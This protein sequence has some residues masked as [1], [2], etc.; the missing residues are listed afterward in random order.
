MPGGWER[1]WPPGV[2]ISKAVRSHCHVPAPP[3]AVQG[4]GRR[5]PS[6]RKCRLSLRQ[7]TQLSRSGCEKIGRRPFQATAVNILPARNRP[8]YGALPR[9]PLPAR[10]CLA[11]AGRAG[12]VVH[13]QAEPGNENTRGVYSNGLSRPSQ[14][15]FDG[16]ER[17]SYFPR[18]VARPIPSHQL[19][20]KGDHPAV[21]AAG[22]N[23]YNMPAHWACRSFPGQPDPCS[24]NPDVPCR[25]RRGTARLNL[26]GS[27]GT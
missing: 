19:E 17:P 14:P 12:K 26:A 4:P 15:P 11:S 22:S 3:R 16:L 21:V 7:R 13:S 10:L 20:A 25:Y 2:F 6:G 1:S 23:Q 27:A 8:G 18:A 9:N 24:E 5:G